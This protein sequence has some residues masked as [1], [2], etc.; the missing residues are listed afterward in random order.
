MIEITIV[1]FLFLWFLDFMAGATKHKLM[2][3]LKKNLKL[4]KSFKNK[5]NIELLYLLKTKQY[6][7][8]KEKRGRI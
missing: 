8:I 2:Q 1:I 5:G 7:K 6:S 3:R 4:K